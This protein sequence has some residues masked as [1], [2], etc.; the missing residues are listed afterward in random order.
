MPRTRPRPHRS[1]T[2]LSGSSSFSQH[3]AMEL[4]LRKSLSGHWSLIDPLSHKPR[5]FVCSPQEVD[6]NCVRQIRRGDSDGPVLGTIVFKSSPHCSL[7]FS[8]D[9][10]EFEMKRNFRGR[11]RFT[12]GGRNL[13]WKRDV[14]CRESLTRRIYADTDEETLLVYEGAENFIDEIVTSFLA[15]KFRREHCRSLSCGWFR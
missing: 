1:T 7:G 3:P 14:I 5:Y 15:M 4:S 10:L 12:V 9:K 8:C 6:G 13:Y 11:H 2:L